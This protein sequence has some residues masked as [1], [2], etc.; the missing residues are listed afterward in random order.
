LNY[1]FKQLP[2]YGALDVYANEKARLRKEGNIVDD[3][4][5][6]IGATAIENNMILVNN[7]EKHPLFNRYS[8]YNKNFAPALF[9]NTSAGIR[10]RNDI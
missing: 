2:I 7:N 3:L 10:N 5:L 8:M 4:D 6:L 1:R 9:C